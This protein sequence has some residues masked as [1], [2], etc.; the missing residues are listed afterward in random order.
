M[1]S[2]GG[3]REHRRHQ[4][5]Y[6]GRRINYP[7]NFQLSDSQ[8]PFDSVN[9]DRSK[10]LARRRRGGSGATFSRK[11]ST[12]IFIGIGRADLEK[13]TLTPCYKGATAR[14]IAAGLSNAFSKLASRN[15][16]GHRC[17]PSTQKSLQVYGSVQY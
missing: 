8:H 11:S 16:Y 13:S 6:E 14:S 4:R 15:L 9:S 17:Y 1:K 5:T 12:E 7:T 3:S 2:P 10:M